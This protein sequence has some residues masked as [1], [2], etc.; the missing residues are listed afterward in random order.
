VDCT[1]G[2]S[3]IEDRNEQEICPRETHE[4]DEAWRSTPLLEGDRRRIFEDKGRPQYWEGFF[5]SNGMPESAV[6]ADSWTYYGSWYHVQEGGMRQNVT[7]YH[8]EGNALRGTQR[9]INYTR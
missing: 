7:I 4:R 8:F 2:L 1:H 3:S 9:R 6:E 5:E